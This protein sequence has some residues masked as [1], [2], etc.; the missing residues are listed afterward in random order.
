MTFSLEKLSCGYH[1][2]PV[3]TDISCR[4]E[5]GE[6]LCIL[7]PNGVGKTTL[8]Q[9]VLG[10][11]PLISGSVQINGA[12]IRKWN[13]KKQAQYL[14]Y[15]PQA[16]TPPFPYT[17]LDVVVMGRI[18]HQGVFASPAKGDYEIAMQTMESLS[19]AHLKDSVYTQISGGERQMVLIARALTQRPQILLMD[20]PTANLDFGNQA[21]VL[22]CICQLSRQ[23]V[24]VIMTSHNPD[25]ALQCADSVLLLKRGNRHI[26]G[27]PGEI[28]TGENM[29][30]AYGVDVIIASGAYQNQEIKGC[31]PLIG[32]G[33]HTI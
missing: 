15:V 11:L 30:S 18:A 33:T 28:V 3:I 22:E 10:L 23:G 13:P 8:F 14:G 16:H 7:G 4:V 31:V 20:E 17:S 6:I 27:P 26:H 5:S 24:S 2:K 32:M 19:I 1:G 25:H 12:D 29:K 9:S 21:R